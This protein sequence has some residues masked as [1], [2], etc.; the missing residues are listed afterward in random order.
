MQIFVGLHKDGAVVVVCKAVLQE[1][2]NQIGHEEHH[3]DHGRACQLVTTAR[4]DVL[5]IDV[6]PDIKDAQSA[7]QEQHGQTK[8]ENPRIE[9]GVKTM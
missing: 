2:M 7:S 8:H 9:Q 6:V 1:Q 3:E 5:I 4:E